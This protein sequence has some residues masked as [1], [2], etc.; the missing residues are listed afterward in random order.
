MKKST[1]KHIIIIGIILAII[2][3]VLGL[4]FRGDENERISSINK[5]NNHEINTNISDI[6]SENF[7]VVSTYKNPVALYPNRYY[8]SSLKFGN[9]GGI[10][11]P[12]AVDPWSL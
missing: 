5:N 4:I 8:N 2:L 12:L 9:Y 6:N 10:N 3:F 11:Y 7:V 1:L